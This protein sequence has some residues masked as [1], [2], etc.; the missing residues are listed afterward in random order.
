MFASK[1]LGRRGEQLAKVHLQRRGYQIINQNYRT[2][3][4]EVDLICLHQGIIHFVEVKTRSTKS[5]GWP[6][7]AVNAAKLSKI[8]LAAQAYLAEHNT[9]RPW[10]I[11]VLSIS[12]NQQNHSGQIK[13]FKNIT[14]N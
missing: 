8:S 14:L 1:Q 3:Q 10:Q 12:I 9:T 11:D 13:H 6:E 2:R 5:Y 4:G 7:E